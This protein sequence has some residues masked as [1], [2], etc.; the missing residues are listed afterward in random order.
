MIE[1]D[2]GEKF[3]LINLEIIEVKGE[4]MDVEGCFSIL[5]VYGIVKW[6][7]EVIVCYYDCDGEEIE[8]IVFGY[9]VCVF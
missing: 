5:Y 6:V 1:V 2:E 8:V 9:L 4:S 3:E 7:D